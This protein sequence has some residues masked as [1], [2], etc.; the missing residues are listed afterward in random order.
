MRPLVIAALAALNRR[1]GLTRVAVQPIG[2]HC[3]NTAWTTAFPH[4]PVAPPISH[5]Q[6]GFL[7]IPRHKIHLLP[8]SAAQKW[9]RNPRT[10]RPAVSSFAGRSGAV[11]E[12]GSQLTV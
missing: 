10:E 12:P 7:A 5:R 2:H 3:G 11:E 8:S 4:N 9:R 6:K 1:R